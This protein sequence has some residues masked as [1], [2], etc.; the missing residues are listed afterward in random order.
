MNVIC[1]YHNICKNTKNNGCTHY[2]LHEHN[3]DRCDELCYFGP[4]DKPPVG[5]TNLSMER[6]K[7]LK[8]LDNL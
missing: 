4:F 3:H 5:C 2:K 8:Q 1:P 6:K 7:K